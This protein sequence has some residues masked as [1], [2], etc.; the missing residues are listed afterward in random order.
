MC[1]GLASGAAHVPFRNS[2]LTRLL[3]SSLTG[4]SRTHLLACVSDDGEWLTESLRTLAVSCGAHTCAT[5]AGGSGGHSPRQ[6][7]TAVVAI[8]LWWPLFGLCIG[9]SARCGVL[10]PMESRQFGQRMSGVC[11]VEGKTAVVTPL[12]PVDPMADDAD[13]EL[14]HLRRRAVWIETQGHGDVFARCLG[15]PSD[16]LLL[17]VHGSGP[18]NSSLQWNVVSLGVA[19]LAEESGWSF[20]N[21]RRCT[22]FPSLLSR[23]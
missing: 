21:S 23:H 20:R 14:L 5:G 6:R 18:R 8:A 12:L 22:P 17:Y 2:V 4:R 10:G 13:D 7:L 11:T 3:A 16:P 1:A 19:A 9:S 15:S